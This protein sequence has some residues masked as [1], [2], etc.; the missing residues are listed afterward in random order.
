M[1]FAYLKI[2]INSAM[3]L[4]VLTSS[5]IYSQQTF[6]A[7][8]QIWNDITITKALDEKKDWTLS[9]G[10]V[11]RGGN[12][13]R[14]SADERVSVGL[15]RRLNKNF[16]IGTGYVY[17]ASNP[18]FRRRLYESRYQ[19]IGVVNVPLPKKLHLSSRNILLYQSL[20]SRPDT[21]VFRSR[22]WLKRPVKIGERTIEPFIAYEH[23]YDFRADS[24]V[25]YRIQPGL[26]T[27]VYKQLSADFY[28]LRQNEGGNGRRPGTLN[29][30]GISWKINL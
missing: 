21:S 13:V 20:Y 25:R 1:K 16:S 9:V 27:K 8:F 29:A 17:R 22:F 3:I 7:D 5:A 6:D 19:A 4:T 23:F 26:T 30:L 28:Y 12:N 14:T 18:T 11:W 15:M 2:F 10:G 24:W